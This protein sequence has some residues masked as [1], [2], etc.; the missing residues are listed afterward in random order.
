MD[1]HEGSTPSARASW[2]WCLSTSPI[3]FV[4]SLQIV[5]HLTDH[6]PV[7]FRLSMPA[8]RA[9]KSVRVIWDYDSADFPGLRKCLSSMDL[10]EVLTSV[11]VASALEAWEETFTRVLP[12]FVPRKKLISRPGNKPW[13]SSLLHKLAHHRDQL[14]KKF[15]K[16]PANVKVKAAYQKMRNLYVCKLTH[17][18]CAFY[19]YLYT[20]LKEAEMIHCPLHW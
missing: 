12:V 19:Q 5:P 15:R 8:P 6:S 1:Q 18:E 2:T 10:S 9:K 13:Y 7:L 11:K 20:D 17:A 14:F 3:L 16:T 4:H